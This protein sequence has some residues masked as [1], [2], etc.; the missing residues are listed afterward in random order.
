M[1]AQG[2]YIFFDTANPELGLGVH[3]GF[4]DLIQKFSEAHGEIEGANGLSPN[5][6]IAANR[7]SCVIHFKNRALII[8]KSTVMACEGLV[9]EYHW[10]WGTVSATHNVPAWKREEV[11]PTFNSIGQWLLPQVTTASIKADAIMALQER[12]LAF[13]EKA[14]AAFLQALQAV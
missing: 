5:G 9:N 7:T 3:H 1:S 10:G 4:Q 12:H 13:M 2:Q 11:D 8:W 6:Y 14:N